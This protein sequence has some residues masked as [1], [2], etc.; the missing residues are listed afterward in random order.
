M[1]AVATATLSATTP[2]A[3]PL[4]ASLH[5]PSSKRTEAHSAFCH[6]ESKREQPH[7]A[8]LHLLPETGEMS[9]FHDRDGLTMAELVLCECS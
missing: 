5:D 4:L 7:I 2:D 3:L 6:S 9:V 8:T 1:D